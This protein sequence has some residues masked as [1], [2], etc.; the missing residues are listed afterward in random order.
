MR[1]VII[2]KGSPRERG[3]NAALAEKAAGG[4]RAAGAQVE[5]LYLLEL[6]IRPCYACDL[7]LD[8]GTCLI[9]DGM[10]PL[11]PKLAA[12]QAILFASPIYCFTLSAQLKLCIDRWY[13]FQKNKWQESSR[14]P[15]GIILTSGD[16]D[17]CISGA[18]NAIYTFDSL[19]RF[20]NRRII[21]IVHRPLND[22]GKAQKHPELLEQAYCLGQSLG[23]G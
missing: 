16:T 6:D 17:L 23:E 10:Q 19:I 13:G 11:Y 21:G 8:Q 2:L 14:K 12:V 1:N 15:I 4:T 18:I 20:L 9:E 3:N 7:C 22:V 5:S